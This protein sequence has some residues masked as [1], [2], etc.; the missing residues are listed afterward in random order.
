MLNFKNSEAYVSYYD[1]TKLM[2]KVWKILKF[3]KSNESLNKINN[4]F[5]IWRK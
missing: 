2:Y 5:N 4:D 1:K 3:K